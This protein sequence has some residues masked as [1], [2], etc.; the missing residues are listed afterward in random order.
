MRCAA[1]SQRAEEVS[2]QEENRGLS[3]HLSTS[4]QAFRASSSSTHVAASNLLGTASLVGVLLES[5]WSL[6]QVDWRG[7]TSA[8]RMWRN[9]GRGAS[10]KLTTLSGRSQTALGRFLG[11]LPGAT[12][13]D[14]NSMSHVPSFPPATNQR[15][16]EIP[17]TSTSQPRP[18]FMESALA[19]GTLG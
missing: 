15:A 7:L 9:R 19:K 8:Q 4:S 3:L 14:R 6:E 17:A 5:C 11:A 2:T 13:R 1:R 18:L 10:G 12:T 16:L